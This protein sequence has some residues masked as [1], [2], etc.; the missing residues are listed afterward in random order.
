[1]AF[2]AR[3]RGSGMKRAIRTVRWLIF[4][5]ALQTTAQ[6][7]IVSQPQDSTIIEG[8]DA[9]F[10]VES[11]GISPIQYQWRTYSNASQF[12]DIPG[13]TNAALHL[14]NVP[15]SF[16]RFAVVVSDSQGAVTSRLARIIFQLY[17]A[18]HPANQ[19]VTQGLTAVFQAVGGGA[20]SVFY[21]WMA[22]GVP[23]P[24]ET[25]SNLV[26]PNVQPEDAG[27]YAVTVSNS[28]GAVTSQAALLTVIAASN[29]PPPRRFVNFETAPVHP[30]AFSQE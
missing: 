18:Q 3:L 25:N 19:S 27:A 9:L 30:I 1:M 21:Q 28:F 12:Q 20:S 10:S 4:G 11:S 14:T 8:A 2:F 23:T 7:I 29:A 22:H 5:A 24:G 16:K 6:P 13:A 26:L 15:F 17:I